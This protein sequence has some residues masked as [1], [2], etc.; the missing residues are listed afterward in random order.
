MRHL[1]VLCLLVAACDSWERYVSGP[2][3]S[4]SRCLLAGDATI[5]TVTIDVPASTGPVT[6][7]VLVRG[8]L[9]PRADVNILK[10][11]VAG[12]PANHDGPDF[13]TFDV[14]VPFSVI[15]AQAVADGTPTSADLPVEVITDCELT[16]MRAGSLHVT[17]RA[18]TSL[19]LTAV[20]PAHG[21]IP[22]SLS[23]PAELDL[24]ANREAAGLQ[25]ALTTTQGTV[26]GPTVL[27]GDGIHPVTAKVL[28]TPD[29]NKQGTAVVVAQAG[30]MAATGSVTIVGPP[31]L[32]P[33]SAAIQ[34]GAPELE[35]FV[36]NT[37]P[38]GQIA[39]SI[40]GCIAGVTPGIAV[41]VG[42][43]DISGRGLTRLVAQDPLLHPIFRVAV[44]PT[45]AVGAAISVT[46]F[47]VYG[48]SATGTYTAL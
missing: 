43:D 45:A 7:D 8:S 21:Y 27:P 28:L 12:I 24:T 13:L 5:A 42:G 34:R 14:N 47:D 3:A 25:L 37:L 18:V 15:Q 44:L 22:S 35:V 38:A 48:Q 46:C 9:V 20:R 30:Q 6:T 26:I 40:A 19:M 39:A 32:H 10:V 1:L 16:P 36:T 33:A 17:L 23:V 41:H 2:D 4:P 29:A 11:L 31:G